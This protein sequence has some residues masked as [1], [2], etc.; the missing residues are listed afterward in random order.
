[1]RRTSEWPNGPQPHTYPS[2]ALF[3]ERPALRKLIVLADAGLLAAPDDYTVSPQVLLTGLLTHPYIK[4]LRYRDTG[5]PPADAPRKDGAAEGWA[6][7]LPPD[8][9]EGRGLAYAYVNEQ[10]FSTG[11]FGKRADYAR[12]DRTAKAYRDRSDVA[13]ADQRELDALA[14]EAAMA[15]NADLFVTERPYLFETRQPV[16]QGVTLCP[17]AKALAVVG[18]YLRSQ[19]E[20]V[21]WHTADGTGKLM[22]N[23]WLYYQIGAVE[24]L[25]ELWRWSS[26]AAQ[27]HSSDDEERLGGLH[28]AVLQRVQRVLRARDGFCRAYNVP[29]NR[30]AVRTM[31]VELDQLLV[32]LMG[33]VDASARFIHIVLGLTKGRHRAGWQKPDWRED[34]ANKNASLGDLCRAGTPLAD[35]LVILTKVRN[36]VHSE[37]IRATMQ[38]SGRNQDAPIC[39]PDDDQQKILEA[40]DALGGQAV[41]GV[42]AAL[43]GSTVVDPGAFVAQLIPRILTLLNAVMEHTP[44]GTGA[45]PST[46]GSRWYDERNRLSIR[47]Q[48]GFE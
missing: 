46:Q 17:V 42:S 6:E 26:A 10:A 29:Q 11:L 31:L 47:W 8:D 22:A 24:L 48:L 5:P 16:A 39:L 19:D 14:A 30:D 18:L 27:M 13:A 28:D 41:W 9:Q 25:P 15:V 1:M 34:V 38:H 33:A 45:R 44:G 37:M 2:G 21:L 35:T 12:G 3:E 7:L 32:L 23:E 20:F 43:D 4:L 40:M 36:T